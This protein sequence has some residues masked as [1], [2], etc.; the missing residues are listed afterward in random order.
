LRSAVEKMGRPEFG[1]VAVREFHLFQ[2]V[3]KRGGAE[4]TRL[5]TYPVAEPK[6]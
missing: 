3:L 5:A 6:S 4:Y 2:S 1:R